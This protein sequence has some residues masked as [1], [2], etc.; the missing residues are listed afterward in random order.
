GRRISRPF[1]PRTLGAA[2]S[3]SDGTFRVEHLPVSVAPGTRRIGLVQAEKDGFAAAQEDLRAAADGAT[4]DVTLRL[5]HAATIVGRRVDTKGQAVPDLSIPAQV[6]EAR[7]RASARTDAQGR[8]RLERFPA[9]SRAEETAV[10]HAFR[11]YEER[12]QHAWKNSS[13]SVAV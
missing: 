1:G 8:Y 3:G 5:S 12:D 11:S 4:I 6:G 13:A 2:R 7:N 10:I 9:S